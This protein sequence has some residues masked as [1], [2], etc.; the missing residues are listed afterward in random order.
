MNRHDADCL[1]GCGRDPDDAIEEREELREASR[2]QRT[3]EIAAEWRAE[4]KRFGED[5]FEAPEGEQ[6]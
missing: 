4:R 3:A 6:P 5:E 1:C 2:E